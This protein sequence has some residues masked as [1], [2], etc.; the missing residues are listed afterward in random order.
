MKRFFTAFFILAV[1]IGK[2]FA[3]EYSIVKETQSFY[4]TSI[5]VEYESV[6]A[7]MTGKQMVSG[8]ITI[9]TSGKA[10]VILLDNHHTISSNAEAP[11]VSGSSAA[12]SL[13]GALYC[14]VS[15]DYIGYG[16]TKDQVHPYLCSRQNA[17]NAIDLAIIAKEI[18]K[19]RG[20]ELTHD[21]VVNVGYSQGGGVA[22]AVHREVENNSELAQ[23]LH[24]AGSWCGDG[25]YDV[26]AT[27]EEYLNNPDKVTYPLGFPLVVN[28]FLSGAPAE[29]KGDLKFSDFFTPQMIDAGLEEWI[30]CKELDNDEINDKMKAV[31]GGRDLAVADIFNPEMASLDGVFAKKYLEFAESDCIY[32]GWT[33]TL[34]I[35]LVH[36]KGDE[37][38]PVVNAYNAIEELQL[39]ENQYAIVD[40]RWCG[41]ASFS[42]Y[43]YLSLLNDLNHFDYIHYDDTYISAP[44][45]NTS[46]RPVKRLEGGSIVIEYNGQKYDVL[47]N[48]RK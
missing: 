1:I 42:Q 27:I 34:P 33:P 25:P 11:S 17:L 46:I 41:H 8:V 16:S 40:E 36:L 7:D 24:F 38:V 22:M 14:I 10:N 31:V 32:K 2:T 20:V 39:T 23:Q 6:S 5:V 15:T 12:G 13:L 43:F 47:G 18:I 29:L 44:I 48:K 19:E 26:K 37:I 21:N 4:Y 35:K 30:A 3:I 45:V 9:P 28:G